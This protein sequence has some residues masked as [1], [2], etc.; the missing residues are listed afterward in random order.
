HVSGVLAGSRQALE[1]TFER[2][3]DNAIVAD[4]IQVQG[5]DGARLA[6][7]QALTEDSRKLVF[8]PLSRWERVEHRLVFSRRFEDVCGNRLGEALD[9]LLAARQRPRGGVL[10]FRP[11]A[12]EAPNKMTSEMGQ[13]PIPTLKG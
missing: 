4:E 5:P 13:C 3:M 10:T 8:R 11:T 9:H 6:G 12:S 2:V 7:T 1:V